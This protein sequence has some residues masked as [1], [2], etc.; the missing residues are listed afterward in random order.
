[1]RLT[2]ASR[3]LAPI[4]ITCTTTVAPFALSLA[5][6]PRGEGRTGQIKGFKYNCIA[7]HSRTRLFHSILCETRT[8]DR[9]GRC[10]KRSRNA[11]KEVA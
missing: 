10:G 9:D 11:T 2:D 8:L 7:Q 4:D 3:G 1:M 6:M 5:H